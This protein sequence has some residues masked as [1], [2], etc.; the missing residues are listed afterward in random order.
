MAIGH[1]EDKEAQAYIAEDDTDRY[2]TFSDP[3][4]VI[5]E[6]KW[7]G[8]VQDKTDMEILGRGQVLRRNF[9]FISALAFS[10]TLIA[11]WEILVSN[12]LFISING[13]TADLFWGYIVA[14]I[15]LTLT[16]ASISEM[17]SMAPTA[18][19]QYHWVSE[20]APPKH[21]K[22]LSY[23]VGW[24]CMTGW[25]A[26][27]L[28]VSFIVG[29]V[30]QGLIV[31]NNPT[32]VF[33]RWH[34]TLLTWAVAMFTV[35]FNTVGAKVL[36]TVQVFVCTLHFLGLFAVII[37]LWIFSSK[38][39]PSEALLTFTNGGGWPTTGLSSMI[40]LLAPVGS[41]FGFD[42]VAAEEV[43]DAGRTL[44]RSIMYSVYLNGAMGFLMAVTMCF[45]M[46]D[47]A[48]I[49]DTPTGYPFIQV[50]YNATGSYTATNILVT[51]FI[52]NLTACDISV[53]AT[54]SRQ[55]WSF[56]RDKGV[57]LSGW[58]AR[59][60]GGSTIAASAMVAWSIRLG[61]Q[62][63]FTLLPHPDLVLFILAPGNPG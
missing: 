34:G 8:T 38:A 25:Q 10:S 57:P 28:S 1:I 22:F 36:P 21:Q 58:F 15:G 50:F 52:I 19:G 26:A 30:I 48:A 47:L 13:G 16:Y 46:G 55:L 45:C 53:L 17:T 35:L 51:I 61:H 4:G 27:L 33:E 63:R 5:V 42:C 40:G 60:L 29:T 12:I 24:V 56:A 3:T 43:E 6:Q 44:P 18:G 2:S 7:R 9:R 37:P 11:T 39:T 23:L 49:V 32:Y 62:Y 14:F 20:F 59:A 41:L 54:A 31:L